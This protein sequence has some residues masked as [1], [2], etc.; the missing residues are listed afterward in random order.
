MKNLLLFFAAVC[1][2][3]TGVNAQEITIS[4][5]VLDE[6]QE[7]LPG[8]KVVVENT[9]NG[10]VTDVNGKYSITTEKKRRSYFAVFLHRIR[11]AKS[12]RRWANRIGYYPGSRISSF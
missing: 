5:T 2:V 10:A 8:V 3:F 12:A 7:T 1:F 11:H 4:G 9:T 6:K